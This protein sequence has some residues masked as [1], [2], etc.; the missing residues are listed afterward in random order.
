[1]R[2]G[3]GSRA[4][5]IPTRGTRS[6]VLAPRPHVHTRSPTANSPATEE[7]SPQISEG[8]SGNPMGT[9][10]ETTQSTRPDVRPRP[11]GPSF[12]VA[13][14]LAVSARTRATGLFGLLAAV[15]A[16]DGR[17]LVPGKPRHRGIP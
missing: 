8:V 7:P 11:Y 12:S 15:T 10:P 4:T 14:V 1:M 3:S 9:S 6:N 5:S 13:R 2:T 16:R 17:A